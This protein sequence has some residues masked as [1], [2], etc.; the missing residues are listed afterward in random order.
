MSLRGR[1]LNIAHNSG[2]GEGFEM[3][4]RLFEQYRPRVASRFVGS[5]SLI[6]ATRFGADMESKLEMF[7][8]TIRRL[9]QSREKY[10]MMKSCSVL[11]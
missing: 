3:Y 8:K 7:D 11:W 5:L 10:L 6:L 4:R 9:S 1:A 2:I